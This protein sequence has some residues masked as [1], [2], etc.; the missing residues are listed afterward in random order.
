M[1]A[2]SLEIIEGMSY[3]K[4]GEELVYALDII[5]KQNANKPGL[6]ASAIINRW[7]GRYNTAGW[8]K[9]QP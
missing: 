6:L 8:D 3:E 4:M 7:G 5:V 1:S 9:Q 2:A